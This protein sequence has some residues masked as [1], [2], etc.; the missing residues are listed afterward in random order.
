MRVIVQKCLQ[1]SVKVNDKLINNID[2]GLM[3]LVGFTANDNLKTLEW[4]VNKIVHLRIFEDQNHIMN[5]NVMDVSG[6]ILSI[7]QFTLYGDASKGN[8]P[9]YIQALNGQE[10]IKLYDTFN[11]ALKQYVPTKSGIFGADMQIS[12]INNGPTTIILEK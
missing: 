11:D 9:S 12:L 1:A 7:S 10:A 2:E 3:I 8:R 5:L 4:M 6:S